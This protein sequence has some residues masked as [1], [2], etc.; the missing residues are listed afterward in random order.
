MYEALV[1]KFADVGLKNN[2]PQEGD[3]L[4]DDGLLMCGKCH[5]PK[6]KRIKPI[7]REIIVVVPCK[8]EKEARDNE[9]AAKKRLD[10][11][12]KV[13]ALKSASIVD[14]KFRGASFDNCKVLKDNARQIRI[15]KRY[16]EKFD[17]MYEKNQG[18][19]LYGNVGTGKS[20]L[21]ACM[22]NLLMEKLVPVYATSFVKLLEENPK[23]V[24]VP[25][26]IANMGKA[27]LV[28][29]DDLG[30]ER[31]TSYALEMVYN[32]IDSRYRQRK[33]MIVTTNLSI[34]EMQNVQD[35]RFRRIYDRVLECC[36]PVLFDGQSFRMM[37]AAKRFDEIGKLL[38]G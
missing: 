15:C 14:D 19:L 26:I 29:F 21:A 4:N 2:P 13:M 33:P 24:D 20:H 32:L 37:E 16:V 31:N 11:F 22:S 28:L 12:D 18:L 35:I 5:T 6:R 10:D 30:A 25:G 34:E 9:A 17:E 1:E 8:C 3:Y 23:N 36:Y 27:Q 7:D 38:G